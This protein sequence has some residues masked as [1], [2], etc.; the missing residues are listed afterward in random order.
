L[1]AKA[2]GRPGLRVANDDGDADAPPAGD[3]SQSRAAITFRLDD[4]GVNKTHD[5]V[6]VDGDDRRCGQIDEAA[7]GEG[8]RDDELNAGVRPVEQER[9]RIDSQ[10]ADRCRWRGGG[11]ESGCEDQREGRGQ[12]EAHGGTYLGGAAGAVGTLLTRAEGGAT[13][14]PVWDTR[15]TLG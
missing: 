14:K 10:R 9:R 2:G 5:G 3:N 7:V 12:E 6:I 15:H 13:R 4:P 11:G 8:A 1:V